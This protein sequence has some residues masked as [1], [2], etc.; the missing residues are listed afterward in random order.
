MLI[1]VISGPLRVVYEGHAD[2]LQLPQRRQLEQ[3]RHAVLCVD[4]LSL[5]NAP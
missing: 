5:E 4:I 3:A 2:P 1:K